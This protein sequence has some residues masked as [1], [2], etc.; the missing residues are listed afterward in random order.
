MTSMHGNA[1]SDR[2]YADL[3]P[4]AEFE[5]VTEFGAYAPLPDDWVLLAGDIVG[6]TRAIAE[7]RYKDVNLVGAAV[8]TAVLNVCPGLDLPFVF[9]GDG[10]AVA[11]PGSHAEAATTALRQLQAHAMHTFGLGLRA[12]A[13]PIGRLRVEGFDLRVRRLVLN[14]RNHLAMFSGGGIERADQ[15]M[16]LGDGDDPARIVARPDEE[17]PDL[18]GL[19]CRWRPLTPER[20]RMIA[21]MIQPAGAGE[22]AKVLDDV[23]RELSV[24]LG[25][26]LTT[27]APASVRSLRFRWPPSGLATEARM[28]SMRSGALRAWAWVTMTSLVQ[29]WC[30]FRGVKAGDYDAP[31][32]FAELAAQTD[33]RRFDGCLRMVLDCSEAEVTAIEDY[34]EDQHRLGHLVYGLHVD[35]AALMT[36]LVFSLAQGEHIHFIDAAGGGFAC[37]A[38][39]L[40]KRLR[41]LEVAE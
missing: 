27:H 17:P 3:E 11:V 24:L 29:R 31:K 7:G 6:S 12:V 10:G 33:F 8:I 4:F 14:G 9:G 39:A 5:R 20:G 37:A 30:H 26:N 35:R 15:I 25:G 32:Y 2:F 34:L 16:K 22:P 38:D 21:L 13:V 1:A 28:L 19:S 23:L 36:C 41:A 40:K 18:E